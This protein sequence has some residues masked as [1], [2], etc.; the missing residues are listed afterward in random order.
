MDWDSQVAPEVKNLSANAGDVG[1]AS[2]IPGLGRPLGRVNATHSSILAWRTPWAEEPSR[3]QST[4][5]QR[6]GHD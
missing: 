1:D 2:S 6:V 5:L 3:P 4:G